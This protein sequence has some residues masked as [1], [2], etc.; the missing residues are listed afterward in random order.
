MP[1]SSWA[2]EQATNTKVSEDAWAVTSNARFPSRQLTDARVKKAIHARLTRK[3]LTP[4]SAYAAIGHLR[5][6]RSGVAVVFDELSDLL[7]V[8][9]IQYRAGRINKDTAGLQQGP[10]ALE[11]R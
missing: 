11:Q 7:A 6:R 8:F 9:I 4:H 2:G 10:E 3:N 5:W 1:K